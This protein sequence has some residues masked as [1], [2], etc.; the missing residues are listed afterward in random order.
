VIF[1]K[2]FR[3]KQSNAARQDS[4][5]ALALRLPLKNGAFSRFSCGAVPRAAAAPAYRFLTVD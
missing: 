1:P 3:Q 5:A 4:D 2:E